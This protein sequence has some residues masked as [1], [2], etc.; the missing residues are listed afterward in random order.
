M[1]EYT[2]IKRESKCKKKMLYTKL[3]KKANDYKYEHNI[4]T[5]TYNN[6]AHEL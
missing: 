5:K 3:L 6:Q 1:F 4:K 2:Q